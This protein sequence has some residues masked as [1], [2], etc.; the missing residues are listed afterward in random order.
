MFVV[1]DIMDILSPDCLLLMR[2][3]SSL[4]QLLGSVF[5][6]LCAIGRTVQPIGL[7]QTTL[8]CH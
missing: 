2:F 8:W 4:G 7:N 1:E 6:A 5:I 3:L